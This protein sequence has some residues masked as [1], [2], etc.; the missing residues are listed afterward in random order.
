MMT[1]QFYLSCYI[2]FLFYHSNL[3]ANFFWN[4]FISNR[5]CCSSFI[6]PWSI[7]WSNILVIFT[8]YFYSEFLS[9]FLAEVGEKWAKL[10]IIF[11]NRHFLPCIWNVLLLLLEINHT[12]QYQRP[13]QNAFV[14]PKQQI[15]IWYMTLGNVWRISWIANKHNTRRTK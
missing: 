11:Y 2:F 4:S 8:G 10:L 5:L 6:P 7:I 13:N 12:V 15:N 1:R 9:L 3:P 14:I